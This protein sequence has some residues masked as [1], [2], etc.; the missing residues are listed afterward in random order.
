MTGEYAYEDLL[1]AF[2]LASLL[3]EKG[4]ELDLLYRLLPLGDLVYS[5]SKSDFKIYK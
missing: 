5:M 3:K 2:G 1:E 4:E